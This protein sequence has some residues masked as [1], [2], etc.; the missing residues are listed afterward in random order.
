MKL[1]RRAINRL[2]GRTRTLDDSLDFTDAL[3]ILNEID[4]STKIDV[5]YNDC[6]RSVQFKEATVRDTYDFLIREFKPTNFSY[7]EVNYQVFLGIDDEKHYIDFQRGEIMTSI[8][9]SECWSRPHSYARLEF[10][11]DLKAED[12]VNLFLN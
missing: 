5:T 4:E 10:F 8:G 1:I 12:W 7:C 9:K 2:Q 3:V 11:P 6:G